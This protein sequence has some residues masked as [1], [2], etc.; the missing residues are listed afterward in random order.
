MQQIQILDQNAVY[1]RKAVLR[2]EFFTPNMKV[3]NIAFEEGVK[4]WTESRVQI[5]NSLNNVE[6]ACRNNMSDDSTTLEY[7]A[8]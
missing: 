1:Y 5:A 3:V 4:I 2:K 8:I 7:K 6:E